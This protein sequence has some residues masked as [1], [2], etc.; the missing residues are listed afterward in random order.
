MNNALQQQRRHLADLLEA[1][2]RSA[3]FLQQSKARIDWP[4]AHAHLAAHNKDVALFETLAAINERFAKLQDSL[5]AAMRHAALLMG[6]D[7]DHFLGVL[8]TYEKWGVIE[9]ISAWQ[10]CRAVRNMAAHDYGLDYADIAEHFNTLAEL[11]PV[12]LQTASNL[13]RHVESTLSIHPASGDFNS[14][15]RQL[16][17][18]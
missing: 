9:S 5:A 18:P 13:L 8:A 4:L 14:E 17:S 10:Q 12:L 3:W 7:P 1:I 2:Q 16:S 15:F 6:E 11:T